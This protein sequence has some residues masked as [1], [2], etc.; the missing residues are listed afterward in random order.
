MSQLSGE[1]ANPD[2]EDASPRSDL[3][4]HLFSSQENCFHPLTEAEVGE[5]WLLVL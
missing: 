2:L 1:S 3:G 5:A 4:N